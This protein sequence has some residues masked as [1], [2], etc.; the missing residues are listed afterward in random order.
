[1]TVEEMTTHMDHSPDHSVTVNLEDATELIHFLLEHPCDF[2]VH[3]HE[4]GP[5][6]GW[7]TLKMDWRYSP[8]TKG[9]L[10]GGGG[11]NR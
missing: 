9:K 4:L 11:Y 8:G 5:G 6:E 1:M 2:S 7:Y 10:R 3:G